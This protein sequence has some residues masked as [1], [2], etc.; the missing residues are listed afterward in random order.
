MHFF[1]ENNL[2]IPIER[3]LAAT[4]PFAVLTN[5]QSIR[6]RTEPIIS[7]VIILR[8]T[9]CYIALICNGHNLIEI[10]VTLL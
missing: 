5:I 2:Y 8:I 10:S 9:I 4:M 7:F 6:A 3:I 1:Y